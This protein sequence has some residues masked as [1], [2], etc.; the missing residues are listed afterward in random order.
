MSRHAETARFARLLMPNFQIANDSEF[1]D[2]ENTPVAPFLRQYSS[3]ADCTVDVDSCIVSLSSVLNGRHNSN[4]RAAY[5]DSGGTARIAA[6]RHKVLIHNIYENVHC[7]LYP[8]K[9]LISASRSSIR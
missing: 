6:C 8:P 9:A 4:S 2:C 7:T 1:I 3:I 5:T